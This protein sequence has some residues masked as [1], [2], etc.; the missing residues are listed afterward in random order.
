MRIPDL[1]TVP[2]AALEALAVEYLRLVAGLY[3]RPPSVVRTRGDSV[4]GKRNRPPGLLRCIPASP[5][6]RTASELVAFLLDLPF[7]RRDL[8]DE[9]VCFACGV[10]GEVYREEGF[11]PEGRCLRPGSDW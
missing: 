7:D 1:S 11:D 6:F 8:L 3:F 4:V 2:R 9:G 10:D 5:R